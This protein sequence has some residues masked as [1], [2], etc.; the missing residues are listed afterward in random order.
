M[1]SV[2]LPVSIPIARTPAT[3]FLLGMTCAPRALQKPDPTLWGRLGQ[4]HGR[5]IPFAAFAALRN[6]GRYWANSGQTGAHQP[7]L[8]STRPSSAYIQIF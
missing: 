8:M 1:C 2:F 3:S 6:L 4:E 5:S 7:R